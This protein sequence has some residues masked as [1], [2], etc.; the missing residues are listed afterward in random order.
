[1]TSTVEISVSTS[2]LNR[3][4]NRLGSVYEFPLVDNGYFRAG[5][6]DLLYAQLGTNTAYKANFTDI[7]KG[8]NQA[9][10]G[11]TA[12]AYPMTSAPEWEPRM[13]RQFLAGTPLLQ[14]QFPLWQCR[15]IFGS[16]RKSC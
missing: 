2:I 13:R 5:E 10:G 16:V 1:L 7:T 4:N 9:S 6:N 11:P 8:S 3:A 15:W 14:F 12:P